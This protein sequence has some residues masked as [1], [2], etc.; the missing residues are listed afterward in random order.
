MKKLSAAIDFQKA[1]QM[2]NGFIFIRSFQNQLLKSFL[3]EDSV[4]QKSMQEVKGKTSRAIF[5]FDLKSKYMTLLIKTGIS[6]VSIDNAKLN[7][8]N[9]ISDWDFE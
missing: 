9:D 7:L 1:G 6:S 8:E 4:F 3:I 2:I 5:Q